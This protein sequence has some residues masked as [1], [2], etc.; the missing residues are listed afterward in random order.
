MPCQ[1]NNKAVKLFLEQTDTSFGMIF[2]PEA[3]YMGGFIGAMRHILQKPDLSRIQLA[4]WLRGMTGENPAPRR[5]ERVQWR[6][7]MAGYVCSN[8]NSNAVS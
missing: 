1:I 2:A 8:A 6:K 3:K 4:T 5:S 7:F